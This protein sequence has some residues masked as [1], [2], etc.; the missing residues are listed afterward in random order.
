MTKYIVGILALVT[1][2]VAP[3]A[4]RWWNHPLTQHER[5]RKREIRT[6]RKKAKAL[7]R[8]RISED[9]EIQKANT[10]I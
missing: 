7:R 3:R 9:D 10:G 1:V 8:P 2:A 4:Y 5:W 6:L